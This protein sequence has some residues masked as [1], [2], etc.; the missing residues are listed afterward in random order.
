MSSAL[1]SL[2]SLLVGEMHSGAL[3]PARTHAPSCRRRGWVGKKRSVITRAD[4]GKVTSPVRYLFIDK[5][6]AFPS[7]LSP[8]GGGWRIVINYAFLFNAGSFYLSAHSI[9]R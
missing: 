2:E 5:L 1:L 4:L 3:F 6:I 8:L 9:S 7:F